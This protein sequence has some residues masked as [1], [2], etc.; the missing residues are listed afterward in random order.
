[1]A[2]HRFKAGEVVGGKY[3]LEKLL[4]EG[5]MGTVWAARNERTD[6]AFAV[7]FMLPRFAKDATLVQRFLNEARVCGRLEHPALVDIYDLGI[8]DELGGAPFLVMELLR[9]EGLDKMLDRVGKLEPRRICP[10][11]FELAAALDLAHEAGIVHRDIKP[12][13]VFLH[14]TRKGELMPKLLDF[15]VSKTVSNDAEEMAL[16]RAGVVLGSP[17]YMS[18]EQAR[19]QADID[20]RADVWGLGVMIYQ[21]IAGVVPFNENNYNA[22][23]SA[24]LTH[25][26][27]PLKE[28]VPG[29]TDLLSETVDLCLVKDRNRRMASAAQLA[30]R[31]EEVMLQYAA[32]GRPG[33]DP[34]LLPPSSSKRGAEPA[35]AAPEQDA[36]A[37]RGAPAESDATEVM[38]RESMPQEILMQMMAARSGGSAAAA[39]P[40]P[41]VQQQLVVSE[42]AEFDETPMSSRSV[43]IR[44]QWLADLAGAVST[45]KYDDIRE[46]DS[47]VGSVSER[48]MRVKRVEKQLAEVE[49]GA[50]GN[51]FET[52]RA[53][54][55]AREELRKSM[56][57]GSPPAAPLPEVTSDGASGGG[58]RL[59]LLLLGLLVVVLGVGTVAM[60]LS[61]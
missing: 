4:G 6:R 23:L 48:A 13:N 36:V 47:F 45:A 42:P 29:V 14:R 57:E 20:A 10:I 31:L 22:V 43:V 26:H 18:P 12:A 1:M 50:E 11:V 15:G 25:R 52:E 34:A 8:A 28:V 51:L 17:L 59:T 41:K 61:R 2:E 32:G 3:R 39:Q 7:K 54:K 21:A 53:I 24:I 44:R 37:G 46:D 38:T 40:Q 27:R 30:S 49:D 35:P 60:L 19:G 16:T 33:S 56:S 58:R 9:G 55:L 5:A